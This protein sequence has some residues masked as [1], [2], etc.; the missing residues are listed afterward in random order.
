MQVF[1]KIGHR[2]LAQVRFLL[3]LLTN[4]IGKLETVLLFQND[5]TIDK[6]IDTELSQSSHDRWLG[7]RVWTKVKMLFNI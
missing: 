5:Y 2:R 7:K 1:F 3:S 4:L 6:L